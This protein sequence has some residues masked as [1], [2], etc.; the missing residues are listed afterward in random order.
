MFY[1]FAT[2]IDYEKYLGKVDGKVRLTK[3]ALDDAEGQGKACVGV[4]AFLNDNRAHLHIL[5]QH[6]GFWWGGAA[7]HVTHVAKHG[8]K[9]V[10]SFVF[11]QLELALAQNNFQNL[12]TV[13]Y[14]GARE[15]TACKRHN[16]K[17]KTLNPYRIQI[18]QL[19]RLKR[20]VAF[21]ALSVDD[22]DEHVADLRFVTNR[23]LLREFG[24]E[25]RGWEACLENFVEVG[26]YS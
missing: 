4:H 6:A 19:K 18:A 20:L 16:S 3:R 2:Q 9:L 22:V 13:I 25:V 8:L 10:L 5:L 14:N 15:N 11:V 7:G 17:I 26:F 21:G 24:V 23:T 1:R 12:I